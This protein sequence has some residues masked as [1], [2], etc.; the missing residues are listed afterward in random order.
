MKPDIRLELPNVKYRRSFLDAMHEFRSLPRLGPSETH[1]KNY[2]VHNFDDM[3]ARRIREAKEAREGSVTQ[4]YFWIV[5]HDGYAGRISLRHSLEFADSES[6]GHVGY[7]IRP[8]KRGRGYAKAALRLCLDE[9]RKIDMPEVLL[10]CLAANKP[11]ER[12]ILGAM[13]EYGGRKIEPVEGAAGTTLRFW[14]PTSKKSAQS[15]R[16]M[17]VIIKKLFK[18]QGK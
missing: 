8:S 17:S 2:N 9:A 10:T 13:K 4:H 12:I 3:V 1:Y 14:I 16:W 18:K 15:P 6:H 7:D 11:S 5:D